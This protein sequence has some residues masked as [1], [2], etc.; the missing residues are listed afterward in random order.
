MAGHTYTSELLERNRQAFAA[1]LLVLLDM[2][3]RDLTDEQ[4]DTLRI[5]Y[6]EWEGSAPDL[7]DAVMDGLL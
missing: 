7:I 2:L 4:W 1:E 5:L 3:G 6:P